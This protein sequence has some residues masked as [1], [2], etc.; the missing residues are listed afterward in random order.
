MQ[1]KGWCAV[2]TLHKVHRT[3]SIQ[4]LIAGYKGKEKGWCAVRTLHIAIALVIHSVD[5]TYS[6]KNYRTRY[7]LV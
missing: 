2:R 7:S 3:Y 6:Y 1:G 4:S 5:P